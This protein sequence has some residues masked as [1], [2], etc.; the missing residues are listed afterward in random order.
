MR[1]DVTQE[2][3]RQ[4]QESSRSLSDRELRAPDEDS[5]EDGS[6]AGLTPEMDDM[7][8]GHLSSWHR[9]VIP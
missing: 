2:H 3:I 6:E 8:L 5:V 1:A 7:P 9:C 4:V